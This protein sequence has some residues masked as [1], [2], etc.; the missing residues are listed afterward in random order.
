MRV[1]DGVLWR[2]NTRIETPDERAFFA[3]IGV[4]YIEPGD[5]R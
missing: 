4:D 5:R 2:G 3:A 1:A